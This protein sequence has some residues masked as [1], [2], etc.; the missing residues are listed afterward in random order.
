MFN[1]KDGK[2]DKKVTI[3][4]VSD[5]VVWNIVY[6]MQLRELPTESPSDELRLQALYWLIEFRKQMLNVL[7]E[8]IQRR[9][10]MAA[11]STAWQGLRKK[12]EFFSTY[13]DLL[14]Q[15]K[16]EKDELVRN[17]EMSIYGCILFHV[18]TQVILVLEIQVCRYRH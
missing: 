6:L 17:C 11:N 16:S 13:G 1:L 3:A 2:M 9:Y 10:L 12:G 5:A 18:V 4:N 14:E 7:K 15:T 8:K